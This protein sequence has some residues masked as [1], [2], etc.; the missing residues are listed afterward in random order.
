MQISLSII[1]RQEPTAN[2]RH[3][4]KGSCTKKQ[5]YQCC[6]I[7][8]S[9]LGLDC[10][11]SI[12]DCCRHLVGCLST[13]GPLEERVPQRDDSAHSHGESRG[14]KKL[15]LALSNHLE[16]QHRKQQHGSVA[17]PSSTT[18][19]REQQHQHYFYRSSAAFTGVHNFVRRACRRR[20]RRS[21]PPKLDLQ[22][23]LGLGVRPT[24]RLLSEPRVWPNMQR[25]TP[26]L[27]SAERSCP[28]TSLNRVVT[29]LEWPLLTSG[30]SHDCFY[31]TLQT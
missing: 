24:E 5:R 29:S 3:V 8:S 2:T 26:Y 11:P 9:R 15:G 31:G 7:E 30:L 18:Q 12:I 23:S 16:F 21:P 17:G 4:S 28:A 22:H 10:H 20:R 19:Q 6:S 1:S 25:A 13:H 27:R 14:P